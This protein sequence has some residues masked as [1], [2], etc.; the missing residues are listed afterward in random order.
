MSAIPLFVLLVV[1]LS[2]LSLLGM[3]YQSYP[4]IDQLSAAAYF[5][6]LAL[7]TP[8]FFLFCIT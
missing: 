4:G 1:A 2:F 6:F 8:L 5:F 3:A 7:F